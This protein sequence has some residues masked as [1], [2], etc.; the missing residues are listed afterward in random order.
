MPCPTPTQKPSPGAVPQ[1]S[2]GFVLGDGLYYEGMLLRG[3]GYL[4]P[5]RHGADRAAG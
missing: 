2:P 1:T 5:E 3:Q 4:P